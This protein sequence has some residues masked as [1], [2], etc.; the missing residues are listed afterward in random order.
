[1]I[2]LSFTALLLGGLP[3]ANAAEVLPPASQRFAAASGP[4]VPSFQR[5]VL[6]LL[7]RL[8][9]NGRA[10]HGSFQGQGGFRLSLFGYDF[11]ADHAALTGGDRPR[12][13][14]QSPMESLMLAKPTRTVAHK[15]GKRFAVASWQH[16]LLLR[17]IE[18][19]AAGVKPEDATFVTLEVEPRE[20]VFGKVGE[21]AQLKVTAV[22]SDG[23]REEVTP[24]CR[25]RSNDEAIATISEDGRVTAAGKG[26]TAVVAFYDNGVA[27]VQVLLPVSDQVG[28]RY[29]AVPTPT[30]IDELVVAKLRK[31]GI[32]PSE[33]CTDAEFFR[34]V[35]LDLTGT[36]PAGPE[37]G[38]FLADPSPD[39]RTRRI[40]ELLGRP[41][42]SAW[43]ATRLCDWS[44][45]SDANGPLGGEQGLRR[46]QAQQWYE[47]VEHRVRANVPYDRIVEGIVLARSR[48][49]E[50]SYDEYC[51]EMS[52]YFRRSGP[53]DFAARETMPYFWTRRA[54]GQPGE[55]ALAFAWSFLG[56]SLQCASCH[57]HPYDQWTKQDFD[58]FTVFFNGVRYGAGNRAETQAMKKAVG[59][60]GDE[61]S[62]AYKRQFVKLLESGQ[63]LPF[64]ELSVPRLQRNPKQTRAKAVAGRVITPK[65]LGGEEVVNGDYADPRQPLM[66]WLRQEDNP[67]FARAFVNRVWANYFNVGL[68]DPPDDLNLA[69]PPSNP[70]LLDY[71][72]AEFVRHQYDMK[73]LH[74]TIVSSR[75]Y[76]LS[77]RPNETNRHDERN[78]SRAVLRRL[79]AEVAYDAVVLVT[80]SDDAR[81]ALDADPAGSRAIGVASCFAGGRAAD[82][83]AVNLFG[84]PPRTLNCDCERST[85]PSL[86]QTVFLR[87]DQE[88][89]KLL[90][91]K[92]GWLKQVASGKPNADELIRQA[93]LRTVNR[94]PDERE[95][96]IARRYLSTEAA[97]LRDLLWVL[98][99]TKEFMINR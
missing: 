47:W 44:G 13:N 38:A 97:G 46:Q 91:R 64:K 63:V 41:A 5:H 73:W 48:Q 69:N 1:M 55:K 93:Y 12:V 32:V 82:N 79:P 51:K 25:F 71:L 30:K 99:N 96:G 94:L 21:S 49:P 89:L 33:L 90:D 74:R 52:A 11:Q 54:L 20:I 77:W 57:K 85:E 9:C 22:W 37:V 66:D 45:N 2:P 23:G 18:A 75:T 56:V 40:E 10:C 88:A 76:Q 87:N 61:D 4:E 80:A 98:V 92:D 29:P 36:L 17:W 16:H 60:T 39:K 24:L 14:R 84:K 35:S 15:G 62:G 7:G 72:S 95:V 43:W 81:K 58:Q 70:A 34:R 86:L 27:P 26:D 28:S 59:L 19:G 31:L 53:A 8:G 65:L 78:Y 50:Q 6:P 68:I 42:Y 3:A 67:Y 83:Y